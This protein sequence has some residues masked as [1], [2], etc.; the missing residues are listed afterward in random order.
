MNHTL[1]II[2]LIALAYHGGVLKHLLEKFEEFWDNL[3]QL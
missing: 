1:I 2:L 3:M